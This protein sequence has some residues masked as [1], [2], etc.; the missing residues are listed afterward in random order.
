MPAASTI[1]SAPPSTCHWLGLVLGKVL[2]SARQPVDLVL[3]AT[4]V[5]QGKLQSSSLPL[6]S[7]VVGIEGLLRLVLA[8]LLR[9]LWRRT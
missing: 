9:V 4:C 2:Y 5:L 8:A 7:K 3:Y 6:E 1:F